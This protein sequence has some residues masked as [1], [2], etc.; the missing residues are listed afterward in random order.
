MKKILSSAIAGGFLLIGTSTMAAPDDD[1]DCGEFANHGEVMQFWYENGYS[2]ENDPHDL[3]RDNDGLPCEIS[4]SQYKDFV[5]SQEGNG[6][7]DTTETEES[8][9]EA[10]ETVAQEGEELP[11]T[12]T[13]S[14]SMMGLGAVFAAMGA[15]LM[16]RKK[17]E[18]A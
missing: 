3:D 10:D 2:A 1:R 18:N 11:D 7:D 13:N 9:T 5:A 17:D 15:Y 16:I 6:G 12:A 8:T 4:S 14:A